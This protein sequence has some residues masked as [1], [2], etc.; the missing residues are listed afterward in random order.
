LA[1]GASAFAADVTQERLENADAEPQNWLMGFQ[2]FSS[3]RYSRLDEI[4]LDNIQDLK[5]AYTQPLATGLIGRTTNNLENYGL[6]DD[7]F[8]YIED[9]GGQFFKLD[10]TSGD[11]ALPLWRAD[12][13]VAKDIAAGSRGITMMGNAI[14]HNLRD[15]RVVA[16]DRDSG[17]FIWD[18]QIARAPWPDAQTDLN[19]VK[20]TFT[21]API[22]TEGRI[23]VANSGGDAGSRGWL[24]SVDAAT[25]DQ[26]WRTYVIPGPGHPGHET[27]QDENQAWKTGGGGMWT[28]GSYDP[29][30]RV[31]IWGTGQPQPMFDPEFRP[32]DNLFTNSAIAFDIETGGMDWYF[33]YTPNEN[34]DYDE[35]G[36]HLLIDATVDGQERKMVAHWGR[37][38]FFYRLDRTNG[39][40]IGATQY[41]DEVNWTAGIDPKTGRP[42]EYDPNALVQQYIPETRHLRG[43]TNNAAAC[44]D[45]LG[46]V[47]WQPP[48][49]NPET[50]I[51]YSAGLDGCAAW[52][53]TPVVALPDGGIDFAGPG[54]P[55]GAFFG[56][57][58]NIK[59]TNIRGLIAA[60]NVETGEL[61]G[62]HDQPYPNLSGVLATA[63]GLIFSATLDGAVTAHNA[64]TLEEVWRF[65]T[66]ISIKA[67][68][69]S[70]AVNGK[71]YI[72]V[73]A[74]G[75]NASGPHGPAFPELFNFTPGGALYVFSL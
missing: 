59:H 75:G 70:F 40:F 51:A 65:Y 16:L 10:L 66:G 3:H 53:L 15:G 37:N 21:A 54:G 61:V 30:Q 22:A 33:Q 55:F 19:L 58:T 29:E 63:G 41:V 2:N 14:Y 24:A 26:Q 1:A 32:G 64:D 23:L 28:T 13:A 72:A 25:G 47:R 49:Y 36:V 60:V 12:A 7:G 5:V 50:R 74:G 48:A 43:E 38:G 31:T 52:D 6:V 42:V 62:T 17:E 44:P 71:Q 34:W 67:A 57:N 39:E 9:G 11:R 8:M 73:T 18:V 69:I 27:W 4:N 46:G 20:E 45:V 35:Q 56:A 68:P